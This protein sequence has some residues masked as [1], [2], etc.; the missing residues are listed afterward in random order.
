MKNILLC[1]AVVSMVG[2]FGCAKPEK[3]HVEARYTKEAIAKRTVE[4]NDLSLVQQKVHA[5]TNQ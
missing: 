5:M 4:I 3:H 1:V 2:L